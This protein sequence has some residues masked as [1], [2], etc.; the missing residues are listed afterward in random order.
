MRDIIS[1]LAGL[2]LLAV[3]FI[4]GVLAFVILGGLALLG[5]SDA[6]DGSDSGRSSGPDVV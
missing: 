6:T 4:A 1:F 5:D 3:L 2:D